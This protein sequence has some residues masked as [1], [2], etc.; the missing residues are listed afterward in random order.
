[1]PS[2]RSCGR[3]LTEGGAVN[4]IEAF[5]YRDGKL[6]CEEVAA[7]ELVA[8]FGTPLYV[9]SRGEIVE[10]FRAFRQAFAA[11]DP[12]IA[13]SVKANGNL[14]VLRVLA[15]EGSGADIVSGGELHRARLA[16]IPP[17]RIVFAGVGKTVAD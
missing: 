4:G 16:G 13:F 8:S 9:Y 11:L 6:H 3:G 7:E 12:L 2:R 17:E 1:M 10:R 5:S 14:S 15:E